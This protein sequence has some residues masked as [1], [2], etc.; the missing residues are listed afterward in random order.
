MKYTQIHNLA[1]SLGPS[2]CPGWSLAI[3]LRAWSSSRD[4]RPHCCI[5]T[6]QPWMRSPHSSDNSCRTT[7]AGFP[8][9]PL[10]VAC[11]E[12]VEVPLP[13]AGAASPP[14]RPLQAACRIVVEV[15]RSSRGASARCRSYLVGAPAD[16]SACR[17]PRRAAGPP[18]Q[19]RSRR[20]ASA[21]WLSGEGLPTGR[22]PTLSGVAFVQR[23]LFTD[24]MQ[25]WRSL[26]VSSRSRLCPI[27]SCPVLK[28]C[29]TPVSFETGLPFR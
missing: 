10:Q 26:S 7:I 8:H 6:C 23:A 5:P 3:L 2:F 14:H 12:V 13:A 27:R 28:C 9:L 22:P 17:S 15:P 16:V 18:P 11:L 25:V 29:A 20:G 4:A 19:P 24:D 1:L 21:S